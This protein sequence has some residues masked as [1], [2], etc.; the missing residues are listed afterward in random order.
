MIAMCFGLGLRPQIAPSPYPTHSIHSFI[1]PFPIFIPFK[2]SFA[3]RH[4]AAEGR[5]GRKGNAEGGWMDR[6]R[7][8]ENGQAKAI[9]ELD[10]FAGCNL[11]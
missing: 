11:I 2:N 4:S 5:E 8:E 6:G 10:S 1:I 7:R 3:F 9:E